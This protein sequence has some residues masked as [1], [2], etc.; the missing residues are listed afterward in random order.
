MEEIAE[1]DALAENY[2]KDADEIVT[3][4]SDKTSHTRH[5]RRRDI[6]KYASVMSSTNN[7]AEMLGMDKNTIQKYFS[8]EIKMAHAFARQK[9]LARFYNLALY[10]TNPADR[11]FALK[12]WANM[13]DQGPT[14]TLIEEEESAVQFKVIRPERVLQKNSIETQLPASAGGSEEIEE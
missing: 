1:L 12:N 3:L 14:E 7:I 5:V 13:S 10:G 8:K 11:L 9:M 2:L 4:V 6:Y